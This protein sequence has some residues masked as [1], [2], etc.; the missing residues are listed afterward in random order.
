M[1][2]S[3]VC[4][5]YRWHIVCG[6]SLKL[7]EDLI[8]IIKKK[9]KEEKEINNSMLKRQKLP[10][11]IINRRKKE[12]GLLEGRDHSGEG[13]RQSLKDQGGI[14]IECFTPQNSDKTK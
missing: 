1:R 13:V 10:Q 12:K 2:R 9:K 3:H 8:I 11:Q 5:I 14:C 7:G 6:E 4:K